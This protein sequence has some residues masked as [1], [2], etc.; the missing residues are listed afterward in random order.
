MRMMT[1]KQQLNLALENAKKHLERLNPSD[2]ETPEVRVVE[3]PIAARS[4]LNKILGRSSVD[5]TRKSRLLQRVGVSSRPTF[6]ILADHVLGR[7]SRTFKPSIE[8]NNRGEDISDVVASRIQKLRDRTLSSVEEDSQNNFY[9]ENDYFGYVS[10]GTPIWKSVVNGQRRT[11]HLSNHELE[12]DVSLLAHHHTVH[13]PKEFDWPKKLD[14]ESHNTFKQWVTVVENRRATQ[15]A[16]GVIDSTGNGLNPLLITGSRETGRSHLIHAISQA[17]LQRH[18]G[19]VFLISGIELENM[20]NLPEG[21]QD[22]LIGCRLL[23]IDDVDFI[24]ENKIMANLIGKMIDYALN[25]NVHVIMTSSSPPKDWPASRLWDLCRGSVQT[26]IKSPSPGSLMLF[27]RKRSIA[28]NIVLDDAQLATLVTH[29]SPSWRST[30]SNLEKV[31]NAILSGENISDAHDVSSLLSDIPLDSQMIHD[32]IVRERVEDVAQRLISSAVD[33]VYSDNEIGGIE[34]TSELPSLTEEYEPPNWDDEDLSKSQIEL[35]ERHVKTTLEDLTPEAPS[36]LELHDRDKHLIAQRKRIEEDDFGTAADILTDIEMNIDGQ[37]QSAEM[38]LAENAIILEDLESKMIDLS[39]RASEA[40][41][42]DL[43]LIADDLRELEH[44]LVEIDPE[45][46]PL[47]EFVEAKLI[48]KPAVRRK[49]QRKT[50]SNILKVS[51]NISSILDSH[52]PDGEWDIDSSEVSAEDL[53]ESND[54]NS[55]VK[56]GETLEPH[57]EGILSTSSLT[58]KSVLLSGEEE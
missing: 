32:E 50:S 52:D 36:V 16:E 55:L 54:S 2:Q 38:E 37:F 58:P 30:K 48:R 44:K 26:S 43:I 3:K 39:Q 1:R 7:E 20:D 14:F 24:A 40:S 45:R 9:D 56:I 6:D 57:P 10:D 21:W 12:Q 25:L 15:L 19:H 47:P 8:L 4:K 34:L 35:L 18:E 27:A 28:L 51:S 53:L 42:E 22:S 29:E 11:E 41:L 23:A 49:K 31:A 33:V 17:I 46:E 5:D 13:I